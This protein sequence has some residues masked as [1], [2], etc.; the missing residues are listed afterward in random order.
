MRLRC[1]LSDAVSRS[2]ADGI[3]VVRM[4]TILTK[5]L[6]RLVL[7]ALAPTVPTAQHLQVVLV[8][9][10]PLVAARV[11]RPRQLA[12]FLL[13]LPPR[14]MEVVLNWILASHQGLW[15]FADCLQ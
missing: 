8:L 5:L 11:P 4:Q 10:E 12:L 3:D 1:A 15:A 6:Y 9:R 7:V 13:A 14:A 2:S